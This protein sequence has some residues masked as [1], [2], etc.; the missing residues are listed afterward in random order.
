[1][2]ITILLAFISALTA[3]ELAAPAGSAG[4]WSIPLVSAGYVGLAAVGGLLHR[5]AALRAIARM[6]SGAR[7][8]ARTISIYIGLAC[9]FWLVGGIAICIAAGLGQFV[10][11]D[12]NLQHLPLIGK[13]AAMLPFFAAILLVWLIEYPIHTAMRSLAAAPEGIGDPPAAEMPP[14]PPCW[15]PG[16]YMEYNIRHNLL[17]IAAP[18]CLIILFTDLM[19][20]Y[21]EPL[22]GALRFGEA[23]LAA[24]T[25]GGILCIFAI[26]PLLIVRI[27]RTEPL[28]GG[29]LRQG[30]EGLCRQMHLGFRD[31]LVWRTDGVVANA[32]MMGLI[33][34]LRYVLISDGILAGASEPQ[35]QSVF[36]HEAGHAAN[37]HL[38]YMM[39]FVIST[40]AL[41]QAVCLVAMLILA[42][43]PAAVRLLMFSHASEIAPLVLML[44]ALGLSFGPISRRM[45]RQSDVWGAWA[46]DPQFPDRI[47]P[48][49][50]EIFAQALERIARL[51]CMIVD[52][53]NWRHGSVGS[54]IAYVLDLARSG[55]EKKLADRSVGRIKK[56]IWLCAAA[57]GASAAGLAIYAMHLLQI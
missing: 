43:F 10:K 13:L 39:L 20:L 28:A 11:S 37:R 49:G 44:V 53:H 18:I 36:G 27:W 40:G 7:K 38:P 31:I 4:G 45:E 25:L 1:M 26:I 12:L 50:A 41:C 52:Q 34:P 33:G 47:T 3:M 17:F 8:S 57:A 35:V 48:L 21:V 19:Q 42:N 23:F 22:V 29:P 46:A 30:M 9:Q 6:R 16:R 15:R 24:G 14:A 55:G 51:N 5:V 2:Q 32:G 54:R 56:I